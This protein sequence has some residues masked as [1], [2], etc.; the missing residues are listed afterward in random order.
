MAIF[1]ASQPPLQDEIDM[2][3]HKFFVE[4]GILSNFYF[5]IFSYDQ[6]FW[7]CWVSK[8]IYFLVS[9]YYTISNMAIFRAPELHS[10]ER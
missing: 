4:N 2:C 9:V 5:K 6:Y 7:Q 3:T 1:R 10:K 8:S